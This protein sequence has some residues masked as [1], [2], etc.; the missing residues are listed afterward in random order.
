M[1]FLGEI[2]RVEGIRNKTWT[3]LYAL[4]A[5]IHQSELYGKTIYWCKASSCFNL[6]NDLV[7]SYVQLS[8]L[9]HNYISRNR[10]QQ[11]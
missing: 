7:E 1:I 11:R 4:T 9:W 5:E 8:P 2:I 6:A 3:S 10:H